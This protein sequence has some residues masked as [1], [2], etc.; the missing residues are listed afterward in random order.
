MGDTPFQTTA[1]G[2]NV[3]FSAGVA[4]ATA[5]GLAAISAPLM[6]TVMLWIIVQ[7]ILV[8]RGDVDTRRG[9]T[10]IIRVAIVVGL[11][12]SAGLYTTYVQ[13][14]FQTGLPNWI[15]GAIGGGGIANT[16]QAFDQI[17]NTTVHQIMTV[18]SQ[19]SWDDLVD[20]FSL[21]L[22]EFVVNIILVVTFAVYEI[23]QGMVTI[24]LAIGPFVLGGYLFDATKRVAENWLG[25]MVGLMLLTLLVNVALAA[26]LWGDEQYMRA[27]L[28]NPGHGVPAEVQTLFELCM[29]LGISGFIILLLPGVAAAI[30]GG[31]GFNIGGVVRNVV[32]AIPTGGAG[33]AVR[34]AAAAAGRV[35]GAAGR[36]VR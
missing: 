25:K 9:I 21:S 29:F 14:F 4:G 32:L 5:K 7:G 1:A 35:A 30:G 34:G 23:A 31:I 19:V 22:I 12:T 26:L 33:V 20:Q 10:R 6:A 18:Q 27:M 11:L 28:G 16:P 17:W 15:A 24:V 36:A 3:A 13:N 2:L 8:M